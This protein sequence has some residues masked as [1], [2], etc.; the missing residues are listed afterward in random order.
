MASATKVAATWLY[1]QLSADAAISTGAVG[2]I[3]EGMAP[4]GTQYPHI[5]FQF[6]HPGRDLRV[7][8]ARRVWTDMVIVVKATSK[9]ASAGAAEDLAGHIDRVLDGKGG[10]AAG[11][12]VVS[13]VREGPF[14]LSPREDGIDYRQR[15]GIYRLHVQEN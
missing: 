5:I 3:H 4:P 15:G 11:G 14:T 2:G 8:G 12:N 7:V 6:Q 1:A 13:C 10:V 9:G